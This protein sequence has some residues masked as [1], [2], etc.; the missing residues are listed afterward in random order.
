MG[1]AAWCGQVM[2]AWSKPWFIFVGS[3]KRL[4]RHRK[5][6][7]RNQQSGRLQG[8]RAID[9][10]LATVWPQQVRAACVQPM[11]RVRALIV[12]GLLTGLLLVG[13]FGVVLVSMVRSAEQTHA[14]I[15]LLDHLD[16]GRRQFMALRDIVRDVAVETDRIV[17][18]G[19]VNER[20]ELDSKLA[21]ARKLMAEIDQS[22]AAARRASLPPADYPADLGQ[23]LD[24]VAAL[25]LALRN[26]TDARSINAI[27][28]QASR[29]EGLKLVAA[30][31]SL[32]HTVDALRD[33][34]RAMTTDRLKKWELSAFWW[35]LIGANVMLVAVIAA[36]GAFV[37]VLNGRRR[38]AR[39]VEEARAVAAAADISRS[40]FLAAASHDLRQPLQAVTLFTAALRRRVSDPYVT[41]LIEGVA[42][43]ATSLERMF[44]GLLDIS[45]LDAGIVAAERT[46]FAMARLLRNLETE[47]AAIAASKGL[48]FTVISN[49]A[50]VH[51]D[52]VLLES[53][54]RNLVSNAIKYTQEGQVIVTCRNEDRFVIVEVA[55]TGAGI[56]DDEQ[57][58][59]FKEFHRVA[60]PATS[61][62]GLGLGLAIVRRLSLILGIDVSVQSIIGIGSTFALRIPVSTADV[63][64]MLP[65][66]EPAESDTAPPMR[67]LL[68]DDDNLL[69][70]AMVAE[71]TALG[72]TVTAFAKAEDVATLFRDESN[73]DAFDV[74]LM[75]FNLGPG[76]NG[77]EVLD[78]L[79]VQFGLA[80]P[81]LIMTGETDP[82]ILEE[83]GDSGYAWLQKPVK[84]EI[85]VNALARMLTASEADSGDDLVSALQRSTEDSDGGRDGPDNG[86][87][88]AIS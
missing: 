19:R 55:D 87:A 78:R 65:D 63:A 88:M 42:S 35:L 85:V 3:A 83:L 13:V 20:E 80:V 8:H 26:A 12:V 22:N 40:R 6:D 53:M 72:M 15:A 70:T 34:S 48:H 51:T 68:L 25:S 14:T 28:S 5:Y 11:I 75:D 45:K 69:R 46:D 43:A 36:G 67:I 38:A 41:S 44:N 4:Y 50:A 24:S 62:E 81:A 16:V 61:E 74:A 71:L 76:P 79:A 84:A 47:F 27:V 54:V 57:E 59:I 2:A 23:Q 37:V 73:R 86:R 9:G 49:R 7:F 33:Q 66:R 52:P 58:G 56:S 31:A 60:S 30:Q 39:E 29:N 10:W 1:A 17:S 18:F 64:Q 77:V 21:E 82:T 32:L